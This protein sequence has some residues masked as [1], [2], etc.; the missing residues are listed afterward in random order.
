[1]WTP[2]RSPGSPVFT[3]ETGP[4]D[5]E[6]IARRYKAERPEAVQSVGNKLRAL[7]FFARMVLTPTPNM[8]RYERGQDHPYIENPAYSMETK[9]WLALGPDVALGSWEASHSSVS[10]E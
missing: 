7:A 3:R 8:E 9:E 10:M 2:F 4:E 6:T 1:M 5:F